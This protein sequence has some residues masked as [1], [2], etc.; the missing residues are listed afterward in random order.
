MKLKELKHSELEIQSELNKIAEKYLENNLKLEACECYLR[1]K[2]F[3]K[4]A[5]LYIILEMW[6][7]AAE[8]YYM[9]GQYA[10]AADIYSKNSD[11][12]KMMECYEN[13]KDWDMIL[14]TIHQFKSLIP[15]EKKFDYLKKYFPLILEN[16]VENVDFEEPKIHTFSKKTDIKNI[17]AIKEEDDEDYDDYDSDDLLS[18]TEENVNE[19]EEK[20]EKSAIKTF[21][22]SQNN[23]NTSV[24]DNLSFME[25]EKKE[26]SFE[27]VGFESK[28]LLEKKDMSFEKVGFELN[29]QK[30]DRSF[31]KVGL[32]SHL[33]KGLDDYEHLSHIDFDDE[34]L[35][36]ENNS[37]IDSILSS[38]EKKIEVKSEYS[39][40]ECIDPNSLNPNYHII[41]TK[42]D[43][44]VQDDTM[45][46]MIDYIK[47][48]SDDFFIHLKDFRSKEILLSSIKNSTELENNNE[49]FVM[50]LDNIDLNFLFMLLDILETFE[51]YKLC[52]FVCNR[53]TLHQRVGRYIISIAHRYSFLANEKPPKFSYSLFFGDK[54]IKNQ[55]EKSFI[56]STAM[57]NVLENI[58]PHYLAFKRKDEIANEGNDLGINT[59]QGLVLL[60]CWKKCVYF[61]DYSNALAL[62]S[63]FGDFTNNQFLFLKGHPDYCKAYSNNLNSLKSFEYLPFVIPKDSF[64]EDFLINSLKRNIWFLSN[65]NELDEVKIKENCVITDI[66]PD[67]FQ[68]NA[69]CHELLQKPTIETFDILETKIADSLLDF[70][71]IQLKK[72]DLDPLERLKTFDLASGLI[73]TLLF[74]RRTQTDIQLN[75]NL[76]IIE[77]VESLIFFIELLEKFNK[78]PKISNIILEALLIPFK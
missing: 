14:R 68:V 24:I 2:D 8:M 25:Q 20:N 23:E 13:L 31:E 40:F 18:E 29:Q 51:Q 7:E 59:F 32:E 76:L 15:K 33:S 55:Q 16:L 9:N 22:L 46:K 27:K 65:N 5:E 45:K 78:S 47:M 30:K 36:S 34:W 6:N 61:M 56:V 10:Q 38:R 19:E 72:N 50:D 41:K 21:A 48:F 66:Y 73:Q 17:Q 3:E 44:F 37:I 52:I 74:L 77:I 57:H 62:T 60:G 11:F 42:G 58:N 53:Y 54:L 4:A 35:K 43:I 49:N 70:K 12:L 64:D 28:N 69:F 63:T 39:G 67:Y 26:I 71:K 75:N 1:S